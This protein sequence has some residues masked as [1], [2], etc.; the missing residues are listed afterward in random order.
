MTAKNNTQTDSAKTCILNG[1]CMIVLP[2]AITKALRLVDQQDLTLQLQG[3]DLVITP[4][5]K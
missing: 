2:D 3:D 1:A 4:C 5:K